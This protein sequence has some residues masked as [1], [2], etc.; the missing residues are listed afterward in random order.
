MLWKKKI[1]LVVVDKNEEHKLVFK[2]YEQ[3]H[4]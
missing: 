2:E 3:E 4:N 1:K